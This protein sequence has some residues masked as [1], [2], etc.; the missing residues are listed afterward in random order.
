MPL[1][2]RLSGPF[3]ET[4]MRAFKSYIKQPVSLFGFD[5]AKIWKSLLWPGCDKWNEQYI[6]AILVVSST[7]LAY[8]AWALLDIRNNAITQ[9]FRDHQNK[10]SYCQRTFMV[11]VAKP[12][13]MANTVHQGLQG[14]DF[15]IRYLFFQN[16][17]RCTRS[18]SVLTLSEMRC[19]WI[20]W[21]SEMR[22]DF[23]RLLAFWN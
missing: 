12:I 23:S 15:S 5:K 16:P 7:I 3:T 18:A 19:W 9:M 4:F 13:I 21:N 2:W 20:A 10:L 8:A 1:Y 17:M 22:W 14:S 11:E 6:A